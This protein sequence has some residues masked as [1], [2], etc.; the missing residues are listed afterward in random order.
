MFYGGDLGNNRTQFV[1]EYN[2]RKLEH[3][4]PR[5]EAT[6]TADTS[7]SLLQKP[8]TSAELKIY[9]PNNDILSHV[10]SGI[11]TIGQQGA[12]EYYGKKLKVAVF[13]G[14][15]RD[16]PEDVEE[17]KPKKKETYVV[18]TDN[19]EEEKKKT[20]EEKKKEEKAKNLRIERAWDGA[21]YSSEPLFNGCVNNSIFIHKGVDNIL[22]LACHSLDL[23]EQQ[24]NQMSTK[25]KK[26]S[27]RAQFAATTFS[28]ES[29]SRRTR[30]N[31][32]TFDL[33][34]RWIITHKS[35]DFFAPSSRGTEMSFQR[36]PIPATYNR[37]NLHADWFKI[38]YVYSISAFKT[39]MASG[40]NGL[41]Q[42][43]SYWDE[44]LRI[45]ATST[46]VLNPLKAKGFYSLSSRVPDILSELGAYS[47][48]NLAIERVEA[49]GYD[50]YV[51]YRREN[52]QSTVSLNTRG[53]VKVINFQNLV[54]VPTVSPNGSLKVRMMFNRDCAPWKYI[55]LVL[56]SKTD[57]NTEETG[58]LNLKNLNFSTDSEGR[59]I[60]PL[61][62]TASNAALASTQLSTSM[63]ASAAAQMAKL[64]DKNGYMFNVGFLMVKV[65]HKLTT[66][67][68]DWST[69]VQTVPMMFGLKQ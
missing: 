5:L 26:T 68:K 21:I 53:L 60:V 18:K 33:A 67:S 32:A 16:R 22:T 66:H 48:E 37:N 35:E 39:A 20:E 50:F 63:A 44:D 59:F 24:F 47:G 19:K 7:V 51:V 3:L 42:D 17:P 28:E 54:E 23:T 41:M 34:L 62:G 30:P 2:P 10:A 38:F 64:A 69:T 55:A 15:Y 1:V 52:R 12:V 61:G 29:N 58:V 27:N 14:Y 40:I 6:I 46:E 4:C 57:Y 31:Q 45:R 56:D 13:A 25:L 43:R 36:V 49:F 9:N 65:I 11:A 8:S